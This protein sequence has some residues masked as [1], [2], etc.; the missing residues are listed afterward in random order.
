[1]NLPLASRKILIRD[2]TSDT[3]LPDSIAIFMEGFEIDTMNAELCLDS[4]VRDTAVTL[5]DICMDKHYGDT[6]YHT[7]STLMPDL[8][9]FHGQIV[10]VS[11]HSITKLDTFVFSSDFTEI[12]VD[13]G[14][15]CVGIYNN[16]PLTIDS[17]RWILTT[18]DVFD[19]LFTNISPGETQNQQ[20]NI[21]GHDFRSR[22]PYQ[23]DAWT[24]DT[25]SVMIDTSDY[26]MAGGDAFVHNISSIRG[27]F[28]ACTMEVDI[29]MD[30]SPYSIDIAVIDTGE[31]TFSLW[32][33]VRC[34][35]DMELQG[36]ECSFLPFSCRVSEWQNDTTVRLEN[37]TIQPARRDSLSLSAL[38]CTGGGSVF[39]TVNDADTF[40]ISVVL[41]NLSLLRFK[42]FLDTVI[43]MDIPGYGKRIDYGMDP[44]PLTLDSVWLYYDLWNGISATPELSLVVG[45]ERA[46]S[47][48]YLHLSAQ[49]DSGDNYDIIA[50]D[51]VIDFVNSWPESIDVSGSVSL[52]GFIDVNSEDQVWGEI[53]FGVPL[54]FTISDTLVFEPESLMSISVPGD[55]RKADIV[56]T[57]LL[58][59]MMNT[60]EISGDVA[61]YLS[62]DP[63]S[64]GSPRVLLSLSGG[65][66]TYWKDVELADLLKSEDLWAKVRVRFF[67]GHFRVF[68]GDRVHVKTLLEI[69]GKVGG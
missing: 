9:P 4:L 24:R 28:P 58:V 60:T 39:D 62:D 22:I 13:S 16:S 23:I 21:S 14:Y 45:G 57:R 5:K 33:P 10:D 54:E 63:G 42:G 3:L 32:N 55:V 27:L 64:M 49:I 53:G 18:P 11:A 44:S 66:Q 65:E 40:L 67:P 30:L 26:V 17:A 35:F 34:E 61:L 6:A 68:V 8:I 7:I 50:G 51:S 19:F 43:T 1:L 48:Q 69:K 56:S 15:F 38:L 12:H 25:T 2:I 47:W 52:T 37:D 29:D 46:G 31:I 20:R 59:W 41:R 36:D